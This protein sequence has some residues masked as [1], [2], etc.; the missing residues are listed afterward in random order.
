MLFVALL[1]GALLSTHPVLAVVA[2]IYGAMKLRASESLLCC[3]TGYPHQMISTRKFD[4]TAEFMLR[5]EIPITLRNWLELNYWRRAEEVVRYQ[6]T[7]EDLPAEL[8]EAPTE[9]LMEVK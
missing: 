4:A 6:A 1:V 7:D 2:I 3:R 9:S 5:K 8:F